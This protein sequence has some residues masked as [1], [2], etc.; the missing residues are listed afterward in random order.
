MPRGAVEEGA[1]ASVS[2]RTEIHGDD[3]VGSSS[4]SEP[5][6][7]AKTPVEWL[8]LAWTGITNPNLGVGTEFRGSFQMLQQ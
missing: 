5:N 6:H 7:D 1:H 3:W 4:E 8:A 2:L